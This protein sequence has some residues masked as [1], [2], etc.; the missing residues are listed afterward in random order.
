MLCSQNFQIPTHNYATGSKGLI[1]LG[2][3][4]RMC[5]KVV[6]KHHD[7]QKFH[8]L[9]PPTSNLKLRWKKNIIRCFTQSA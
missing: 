6:L 3:N 7:I 9:F 1:L 5:F 4:N 2:W 8:H